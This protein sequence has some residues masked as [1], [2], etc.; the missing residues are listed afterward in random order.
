MASLNGTRFSRAEQMNAKI[1]EEAFYDSEVSLALK[2]LNKD[3]APGCD[4]F[5]IAF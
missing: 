3:K 2:D 4:S 5:T 1:L